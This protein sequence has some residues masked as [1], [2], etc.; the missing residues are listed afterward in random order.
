MDS[1]IDLPPTVPLAHRAIG[2]GPPLVLVTGT[3]YPGAT[4]PAAMLDALARDHTVVVFDHRGTGDTPGTV[5]AY[6]TRLFAA[7]TLRLVDE[8]GLG[9]AHVLGH[10]M[11]GRVAQWMALD[12]PDHVRSLILAAS[13]PGRFRDDQPVTRGIP[14]PAAVSLIEKGY[15]GFIAAQILSTFFT[16]EF[17]AAD[18]ATVTGLIDAFWDHRPPLEDYLKHVVARQCHQTTELLDRITVPTLVV[19][20]S[21]DTHAGGTGSHLDQSRFL[22]ETIPDAEFALIDDAA[23]GYFW[24][25]PDASVGVLMDFL[26]RQR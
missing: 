7:D 14:I 1:P 9:P 16:P 13:G 10:S 21:R 6:S 24:S 11:G 18:P 12:G 23:H 19:V 8:I 15:E 4:W 25:H 5:D 17:G 26:S 22:A 3:G 2:A 20:G